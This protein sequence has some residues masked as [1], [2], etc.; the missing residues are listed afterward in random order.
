ML[1]VHGEQKVATILDTS[2][3]H[4]CAREWEINS[5]EIQGPATLVKVVEVQL[6]EI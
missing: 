2:I 6:S 3:R 5:T 1:T 4:L